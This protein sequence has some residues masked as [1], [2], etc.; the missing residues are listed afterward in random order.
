MTHIGELLHG[1]TM[2][3][4]SVLRDAEGERGWKGKGMGMGSDGL[5]KWGMEGG[6]EGISGGRS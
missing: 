4:E 6:G 3:E 1:E 5:V 2:E